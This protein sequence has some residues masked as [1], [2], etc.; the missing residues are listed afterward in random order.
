[1]GTPPKSAGSTINLDTLAKSAVSAAAAVTS[2]PPASSATNSAATAD[3]LAHHTSGNAPSASSGFRE[4]LRAPKLPSFS[5]APPPRLERQVVQTQEETIVAGSPMVKSASPSSHLLFLLSGTGQFRDHSA[6]VNISAA[7]ALLIPAD[8]DWTLASMGSCRCI[9]ASFLG[10]DVGEAALTPI[11]DSAGRLGELLQW[12]LV[13]RRAEFTGAER[14]RNSLLDVAV[15]EAE[16]LALDESGM[17]EKKIRAYV[18][19]HISEPLSL[20]ELAQH[21]GMGRFHL[22]R[23]Y[24][25]TTGQTPMVAVRAIRMEHARE[26]IQSTLLPLSKIALQVGLRSEQHLSRLLKSHFGVGI[27]QLRADASP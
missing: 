9:C 6:E 22:C 25:T 17:L 21:V 12:L 7:Q 20:D 1:M 24:H 13:E 8:R 19:D 16:R 27:R 4:V 3:R 26:L 23:K 18:L 15:H 2:E 11:R 10:P 5:E 14:Y